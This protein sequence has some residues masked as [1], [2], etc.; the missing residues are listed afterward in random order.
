MIPEGYL[1]WYV[2]L[3]IRGGV[4]D[5]GPIPAGTP[6]SL[7]SN[8]DLEDRGGEVKSVLKILKGHL[9]DLILTKINPDR[10]TDE[11]L[12]K[13]YAD[14]VDPLLKVSKCP[15]FV[16]NRGHYFGTDYLPADEGQP[17]LGDSDKR[18]LI[19]FLKTM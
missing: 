17:G 9:G 4:L 15:D 5:L 19:E 10:I 11:E 2:R 13:V 8:L 16:V 6:V 12:R 1:P 18:A 3:P 14:V 7:I